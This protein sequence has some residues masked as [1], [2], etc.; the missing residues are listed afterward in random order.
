M[1][2]KELIGRLRRVSCVY[3]DGKVFNAATGIEAATAIETLLAERDAAV[4]DLRGMC[5]CCA[6]GKP[7]EKAGPLNRMTGCKHLAEAGVL[8]CGGRNQ[9]CQ[10]WQWRGPQKEDKHE[11]D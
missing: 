9:K 8:A 11:A 2:Y 3:A 5:W 7:L 10:H 6:N 1:D 4:E